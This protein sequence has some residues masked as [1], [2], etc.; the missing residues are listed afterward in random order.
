M[1]QCVEVMGMWRVT[2]TPVLINAARN[3]AFVVSGAGKAEVLS[4]VLEGPYQPVL[5][6][7]Q[8]IRRSTVNC[9]GCWMCPQP[10]D[11]AKCMSENVESSDP[12]AGLQKQAAEYTLKYASRRRRLC[13]LPGGFAHSFRGPPWR[14]SNGHRSGHTSRLS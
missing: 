5:L 6:P 3:V 2:M 4:K 10:L 12:L 14:L 8:T 11:C 13:G 9:A 1:A 7:S